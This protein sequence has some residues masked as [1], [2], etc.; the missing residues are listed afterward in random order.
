MY[1]QSNSRCEVST[2][3]FYRFVFKIKGSARCSCHPADLRCLPSF[4]SSTDGVKSAPSLDDLQGGMQGTRE[5]KTGILQKNRT[6]KKKI[7]AIVLFYKRDNIFHL[8]N[9]HPVVCR[10][11]HTFYSW[12]AIV[13]LLEIQDTQELTFR[14]TLSETGCSLDDVSVSFKWNISTHHV[15]QQD[16]QRPH[17]ER[18]C[19]VTLMKDPLR[20][21]VNSGS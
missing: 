1:N 2:A 16:A 4:R 9:I 18:K 17:G 20:W 12:K 3:I 14:D 13:S 19:F 15:K 5:L 6:G 11:K 10:V 7:S 8:E 21:A